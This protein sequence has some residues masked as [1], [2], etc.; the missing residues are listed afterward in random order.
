VTSAAFQLENQIVLITGAG[1]GIGR[2]AAIALATQGAKVALT[3]L[4]GRANRAE[5]AVNEVMALGCEAMALTLDVRS[6]LGIADVIDQVVQRF[7]KLDVLI[8]NAGTQ[9][10]KSALEV[11]EDEFDEV[12]DINLKGAFFCA[13]AAATAML[14]QGR[15]CIINVASQHGIVGNRLRAPYCASKGGLINLTRALAVEWAPYRIRVNAVSPTFVRTEHNASLFDTQE[16]EDEI[17][18][19]V[20]LGRPVTPEEVASGIVYL[21]SS[22]AEMIT[23][24]NLVIDGGWTAH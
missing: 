6:V 1:S 16:F 22:A 17:R 11:E 9:L 3:E 18:R 24:H 20:L 13:Q 19:D 23:G 4:P 12:L 14:E 7:G 8:N 15:G 5:E 10:L 21:A 2:A